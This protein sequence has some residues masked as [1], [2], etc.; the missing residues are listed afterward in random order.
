[1]TGSLSETDHRGEDRVLAYVSASRGLDLGSYRRPYLR[2]RIQARL[3]RVGLQSYCDYA[4]LLEADPLEVDRLLETLTINVTRF[5][6]DPAT[7]SVM[8]EQV[9]PRLVSQ[10]RERGGGRIRVWSAACATGEEPYSLSMVL[11]E[12]LATAAGNVSATIT[13]TDLDD[14]ALNVARRGIYPIERLAELPQGLAEKHAR[15][16]PDGC[17]RLS[18][19][20]GTSISFRPADIL[21][22]AGVRA[23]DIVTCRNLLIYLDRDRQRRVLQGLT[24]C[25]VDGGYLVLGRTERLCEEVVEYFEPVSVRERVYR[26]HPRLC[27][28]VRR[29]ATGEPQGRREGRV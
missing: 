24:E 7:W 21:S 14:T 15:I 11:S 6:R 27:P 28:G 19:A 22:A 5:F 16:Q 3:H 2:R 29:S 18:A 4:Q 9:V 26:K 23:A 10:K 17:F 13:A 25:L 20:P 1:M 12:A 8:R